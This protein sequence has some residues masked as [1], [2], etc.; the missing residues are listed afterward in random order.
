VSVSNGTWT[1]TN[2][3]LTATFTFTV[4]T[5]SGTT[6]DSGT[7]TGHSMNGSGSSGALSIQWPNQPVVFNFADGTKL[8]VTLGDVNH[9][10]T[11]NNCLGDQGPYSLSGTFLVENGP[12]TRGVPGPI[13]G[14]GLPGLIFA[15]GG[16][17]GWWRRRKSAA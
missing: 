8:D 13:A 15:A 11:G 16:M 17:L 2:S 3:T 14:A 4:P 10:C 6:T 5:P 1:T 12:T 9:T 7:I